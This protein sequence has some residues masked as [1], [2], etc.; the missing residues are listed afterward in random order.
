MIEYQHDGPRVEED[1]SMSGESAQRSRLSGDDVEAYFRAGFFSRRKVLDSPEAYIE[2]N[3]EQEWIRLRTPAA[4]T[5]PELSGFERITVD[6]V[7]EL[8]AGVWA[9]LR[10][11]AREMH[12]EAYLV[13]ASVVD[14]MRGG[15]SFAAA[16]PEGVDSF[17]E[18]LRTKQKLSDEAQ[19][20]LLG[21][22]LLAEHSLRTLS[23]DDVMSAWLG[24]DREEHDFVFL[25]FDAEVK[26]T[27]SEQRIHLINSVTQ[28]EPT[29]GRPLYMLSIQ[30]TA[31]GGAK[32]GSTLGEHI[33]AIRRLLDR[34]LI[35]AFESRLESLGWRES[36]ADEY[37]KQWVLR[38]PPRAYLVD[39]CFPAITSS[40][41]QKAVPQPAL[42]GSVQ[43]RVDVTTVEGSIAPEPVASFTR[44][45]AEA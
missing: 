41:L 39:D 42:V 6:V 18:L 28:L 23:A 19:I 11:D 24:P 14:L 38:T 20:G 35:R 4:E 25:S 34:R 7:D 30:V 32:Q 2:F 10:V 22:L 9:E 40:R 26:T 1:K 33:A 16:I 37:P 31:A 8:G 43:Y 36:D 13:L 29:P 17:R 27:R 5:A 44:L 45:V 12:Y 21:E 3:P 15:L